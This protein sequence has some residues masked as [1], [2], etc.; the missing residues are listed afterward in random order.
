MPSYEFIFNQETSKFHPSKIKIQPQNSLHAK[1]TLLPTLFQELLVE[2]QPKPHG[3][4]YKW[5]SVHAGGLEAPQLC[6]EWQATS[7]L[8]N[9]GA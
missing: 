3:I 1:P 5:R 9:S 6:A 8:F 4:Y 2:N 7:N